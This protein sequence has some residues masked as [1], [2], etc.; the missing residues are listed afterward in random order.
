MIVKPPPPKKNGTYLLV[1]AYIDYNGLQITFDR[2]LYNP[3]LKYG[4]EINQGIWTYF[5]NIKH[6]AF[7]IK[8]TEINL[9][10][11]VKK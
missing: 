4:W 6:G 10:K 2:A 1:Y 7:L 5:K 3:R 11:V 8:W 9:S